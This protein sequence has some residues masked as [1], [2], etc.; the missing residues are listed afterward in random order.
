MLRKINKKLEVAN[1]SLKDKKYNHFQSQLLTILF[2]YIS[3][4]F[5]IPKGKFKHR[6]H[7]KS[8]NQT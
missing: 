6:E 7:K 2:F 5:S 4:K 8:F 1:I 3:E